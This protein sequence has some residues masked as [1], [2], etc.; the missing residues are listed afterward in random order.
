M[1]NLSPLSLLAIALLA[2]GCASLPPA[3][4]GLTG[5]WRLVSI[6]GDA[7][8]VPGASLTF[9]ADG[10]VSGTTGCNRLS[11]T[12]DHASDGGLRLSPLATTRVRIQVANSC[13]MTDNS[14][15]RWGFR[16]W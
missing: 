12:Y 6:A 8:D 11:G 5:T 10:R 1:T 7:P 14:T 2:A 16:A 13:P 9:D 3:D 4:A 15:L